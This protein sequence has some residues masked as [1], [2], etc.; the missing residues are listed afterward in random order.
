MLKNKL[1]FVYLFFITTLFINAEPLN[2]R[3]ANDCLRQVS[4]F[5]DDYDSFYNIQIRVI[6]IT[7]RVKD[8]NQIII[9]K[10]PDNMYI[11]LLYNNEVMMT[12][13]I[14]KEKTKSSVNNDSVEFDYSQRSGFNTTYT[15]Y[16]DRFEQIFIE[17]IFQSLFQ[18]FGLL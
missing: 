10:K 3:T 9:E 7:G 13:Y 16:Y 15:K 11:T 14:E 17:Q 6:G 12:I 18:A 8:N 1:F 5:I 4:S 2:S